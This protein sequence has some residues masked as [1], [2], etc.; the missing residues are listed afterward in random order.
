MSRAARKHTHYDWARYWLPRMDQ[1]RCLAQMEMK[2]EVGA[3]ALTELAKDVIRVE[4]QEGLFV[5][6]NMIEAESA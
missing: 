1:E 5:F 4:E 2:L 6:E 3:D